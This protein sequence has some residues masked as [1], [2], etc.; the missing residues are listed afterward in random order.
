MARDREM[1]AIEIFIRNN[2][3][4]IQNYIEGYKNKTD[5]N[6]SNMFGHLWELITAKRST[7]FLELYLILED[8]HDGVNRERDEAGSMIEEAV[9]GVDGYEAD[10]ERLDHYTAGIAGECGEVG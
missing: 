9:C 7:L 3:Q 6:V 2:R 10:D 5:L 1:D 8:L 4:S